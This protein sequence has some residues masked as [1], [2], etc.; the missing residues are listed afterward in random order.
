M[1]GVIYARYSS[2]NQREES[3]EGQLRECKEYAER[4][5]ITILG[6]YI[7]RAL[8]AKTDNRPEFQHMIKESAKGLFDVVLVW[9]LDRFAR[10]RYDSA[11]YKNLL[12]KNGVKVISARENISEGSEGII[13]EA[14]LEGYAEYYSAELSEKVIRGLTDNALKCKYNGGTV[15]MGYYIDEQQYYQIDPKTAP[16][17]LEMFTKYSEGATM[18]ELVNLLNSRGMR[19]IR[20][21]KIT[22][23]IMNHLLKNRR[24]MGEYSYRDVVKENGI[25]AIV[26]KELFERVQERLAKN[27]KAPA[28]HKAEDDY[29]LTTKL[30]CGKCGSF[31]VGESG[32]SHTMKVHRYYRCVNTKKKKLCDKKAV[33]KDWIEDLV[34]N[35]TMKAIMNDEVMER[36]ID[37]LMELQKKE[38]TDLPLLKKQLAETEKGINNMLN[39]IQAGI[40]T[41][42][43]KQRLD[44]LEET[45]SQ[46]EVSI[47]QEEMH[48]PLLTREQIAFFIYRFRKFDV[49]KREQR[50]RLI[51]SF[52][53]A[54]YLYEDKIILTFNYK[55]GS[56]TITLA[57]V[58]GSD[59]SVLGAL[60]RTVF[61]DLGAPGTVLFLH[62]YAV[63]RFYMTAIF[64]TH[65]HY[66]DDAFNDDREQLL[67]DLPGQGI[68]RVVDVGASL[69]SCRKVLE[70]M[71]QY[72][73]IYGAIGVHPSET[74]E[75]TEESYSW[76]KE[77]CQKE[78]CLAVGEIGLDYYWPEPDHETQKKWFLRQLELA[79]EIKK[80]VIIHSRDAAKDTVDLMTEAHAEEIGG[81]IHCYSY[82]KETA[83]IFLDMGFYF[84]IGGVLTFKNAKKLK[85]AVE[86]IPMDRIVLETDC[87]YLAPEPN[88]GKRNSSLN[89]P[90][91]IA[92]MAQIKGITEEEVRKAA[93]DNSL[94]LYRMDK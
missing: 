52:V 54:V 91:V 48:K 58:E 20:G 13:L 25:P 46:L 12:K 72:D 21:G 42:S 62:R 76:L 23:N 89:I 17:V 36:L 67:A 84:G 70:M 15:P 10:N 1:K 2:D 28:R 37:T 85:E 41:P 50:Q 53:N 63:R 39:A 31:M 90:Y 81:V 44:E 32:T 33:K 66:D 56:K 38:S 78:K 69:A 88:R 71:E 43:T 49:T 34:V 87:P 65:A 19:S 79:R 64:D 5:D 40:F 75:L 22:L 55:D 93:W 86:Y 11:R 73:Y 59:L 18:Q 83:K 29:L 68:A 6:T 27:K 9:K 26:P 94:K 16:V 30:Y 82:T 4:N 14:M 92:A 80:P 7:D 45:K 61:G 77:Q 60:E 8:S 35:Y 51:D 47:L 57:E 74:A 24:Y 3:I